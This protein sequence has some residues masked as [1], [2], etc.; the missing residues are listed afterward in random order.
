MKPIIKLV[1]LLQAHAS[2]KTLCCFPVQSDIQSEK[3]INPLKSSPAAG[4][5]DQPNRHHCYH[6]HESHARLHHNWSGSW[7]FQ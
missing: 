7:S 6:R 5:F 4:P 3:G 1:G 2:L